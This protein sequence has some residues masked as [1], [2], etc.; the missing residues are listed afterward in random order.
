MP[1]VTSVFN[2]QALFVLML[3]QSLSPNHMATIAVGLLLFQ[4]VIINVADKEA[5][6]LSSMLISR[7]IF[8]AILRILSPVLLS[9]TKSYSDDT[10]YALAGLL[11]LMHLCLYDYMFL[12]GG[13]DGSVSVGRQGWGALN[14]VSVVASLL[15]SRLEDDFS[16]FAIILF[17]VEMFVFFP[18]SC[19]YAKLYSIELHSVIAVSLSII[20][21]GLLLQ[22]SPAAGVVYFS[23]VTFIACVC[24]AWMI[25]LYQFK[26]E[27]HGPWDVLHCDGR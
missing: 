17:A 13:N 21:T 16:V 15:A 20:A 22:I 2:I 24:P 23:L 8:A 5:P 25:G 3:Q 27:I 9:L 1:S 11:S 6:S 26:Q 4:P 10:L 12:N 14:C 18:I 19:R 7:G